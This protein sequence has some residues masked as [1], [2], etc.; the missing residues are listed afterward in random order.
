MKITTVHSQSEI[1]QCFD[2]LKAIWKEEFEID[3]NLELE[4]KKKEF[5]ISELSYIKSDNKIVSVVQFFKYNKGRPLTSGYVPENDYSILWRV[6]TLKEYRWRW[7]WTA[8][9]KQWFEQINNPPHTDIY[10]P[11][12]LWNLEYYR[13]FWFTEF[14]DK[15]DKWNAQYIYMKNN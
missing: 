7:F 14:W 2:F 9:I 11:S 1:D 10:I 5:L 6:W 8:L 4:E 3:W 12:E 13:K 15:V